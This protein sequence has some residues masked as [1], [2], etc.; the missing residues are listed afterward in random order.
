MMRHDPRFSTFFSAY[1]NE[2]A[3]FDLQ[4]AFL[5]EEKQDQLFRMFAHVSLTRDPRAT[6]DMV[7]EEA[8]AEVQPDPEIMELEEERAQLKQ[9]QYR[10]A[11]HDSEA[12]IR[13][14][15]DTIRTKKAER[16][17][18]I[19]KDYR[20]YYFYHRPTW[21]IEAQARGEVEEQYEE[22]VIDLIVPERARLAEILCFQSKDLTE[23]QI[24]RLRI[25]VVDLMVAL[26]DKRDTG[27]PH[28]SQPK[29]P[30]QVPVH[31]FVKEESPAFEAWLRADPFP[32]LMNA[33]QCP[34]CIG[35]ERLATAERTFR[36][37][38]PT[39][40]NDHFDDQ[41]LA[42]RETAV[43][44]GVVLACYH[45]KCRSEAFQ[46]LDHFRNHVQTVHKV[47]LRTTE[48]VNR[49]RLKQEQRRRTTRGRNI[50][51]RQKK[52]EGQ[53]MV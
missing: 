47:S 41:H 2:N 38:R 24:S 43:A 17:K 1:L 8:W 48:Q 22:P 45:P 9:G 11:G 15:T 12:R 36:W 29:P 23:E 14:L 18:R 3:R 26:C 28:Q 35:D 10:I 20:E 16:D 21:D 37:C 19:V 30:G 5:E 49:R 4:N 13:K 50:Q 31:Q 32:L 53:V 46:H 27:K 7:P 44:Q 34:D 39:I 40:R 25:E 6:R 52:L 42:E 33:S 51:R